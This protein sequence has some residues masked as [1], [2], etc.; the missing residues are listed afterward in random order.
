MF[1]ILKTR[2]SICVD[3]D[4]VAE[5]LA[6]GDAYG[7]C[8]TNGT[9]PQPAIT[10][11]GGSSSSAS[12][13]RLIQPIPFNA[14]IANN[15]NF[16]GSEYTLTIEGGSNQNVHV[17]VTNMYGA[18]VFSANGTATQT[19]RFGSRFVSGTYIVQVIQGKNVKTLKV[20]KGD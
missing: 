1:A 17:I 16:G 6:H 8:P 4:A 7:T 20:I 13:G 5:H 2:P 9:C 12:I 11:N 15:P 10:Q 14:R 18:K 19:Y 3:A